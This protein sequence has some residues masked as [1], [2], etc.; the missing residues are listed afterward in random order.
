M[1]S[2]LTSTLLGLLSLSLYCLNT[3]FCFTLLLLLT[4]LKLLVPFK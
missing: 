4:L 1:P 2:R 3:L